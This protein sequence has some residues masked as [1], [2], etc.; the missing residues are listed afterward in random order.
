M[1]INIMFK[2]GYFSRFLTTVLIVLLAASALAAQE[3]QANWAS[4]DSRPTPQ[5]FLDAKFGIF[6]HWGVYSV[7]AW[8]AEKAYSEWYWRH[9]FN[10][11][12][13]L[14]D[15]EWGRFHKANYGASLPYTAF[16]PM[17]KCEMFDPDEWADVFARAGA[18][19]VVL[20][21]KHHDGFCLWP[22]KH[23]NKTWGMLWNS[24]D[25]GPKRD[26]LGDLTEAVRDTG[27]KMG[28]YY[29]LYEWF[30]PLWRLDKSRYV[31]EHMAPQFM[32]VVMRYKPSIIFS[33]G[34]WDLPDTQWRS[35]ELLAWL[36]NESPCKNEVAINDR[37]GKDIRHK[38]GGYYTT[39]YG[40]GLQESTHPWEE[41]RGIGY[42][43]GY[44][45]N[46]PLSNYRSTEQL[47]FMLVDLVS[48][49]GNLLL[50]VGPTADGR[51][52]M[53]M[54]S[55]LIEMG[56]WLAVNGEAI[57]ATRPW[58][59]NC[60]WSPGAMPAQDFGQHKTKYD[61][62]D[63]V[64]KSQGKASIQAFFTSK[65]DLLYA[66]T[67]GWPGTELVLR[68]VRPKDGA[69][70]TMLGAQGMLS[71]RVNG[72]NLVIDVSTI[73]ADKLPC[74]WAYAF[75]IPVKPPVKEPK[76]VERKPQEEEPED[77]I[78]RIILDSLKDIFK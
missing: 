1:G 46:E 62:M 68:N 49:G 19:Y 4:L 67:P 14:Q 7:P 22:S 61:V 60:Q 71:W 23:A 44:N 70:I 27:L 59:Q 20:T 57:Y 3:Y 69:A 78:E 36:F 56:D 33:D 55:R 53:I 43:F 12:G 37:W 75:K 47:I 30:N 16:A 64:R 41:N 24:V 38:H 17:F 72:N 77:D 9:T 35:P 42:S 26:L 58:S 50:D 6:I 39:E 25:T 5:W 52:P 74:Q 18:K 40:A 66:I 2:N 21:S 34:E 32:D 54:Q 51:I 10:D 45:R 11:D 48:R 73:T 31:A 8:G 13:T 76:P 15:N 28:F 29:S 65:P 63:L